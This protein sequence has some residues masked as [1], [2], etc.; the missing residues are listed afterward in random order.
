MEDIGQWS[1]PP[2]SRGPL[3]RGGNLKFCPGTKLFLRPNR[4][5]P[6]IVPRTRRGHSRWHTATPIPK[7]P[8]RVRPSVLSAPAARELQFPNKKPVGPARIS[9]DHFHICFLLHSFVKWRAAT[10]A[11]SCTRAAASYA[12]L[13][14]LRNQP[15]ININEPRS[16]PTSTISL[17]LSR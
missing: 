9:D 4:R 6:S 2:D 14:A 17:P 3:S 12:S 10:C 7:D 1:F 11:V 15:A 16:R 5:G 8:L 13:S